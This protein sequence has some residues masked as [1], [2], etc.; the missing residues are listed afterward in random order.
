M[1]VLGMQAMLRHMAKSTSF[2]KIFSIK[3]NKFKFEKIFYFLF[4]QWLFKI[5]KR[6]HGQKS[7]M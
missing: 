1:Q 4:Q 5:K 6:Q 7:I 2:D 3:R